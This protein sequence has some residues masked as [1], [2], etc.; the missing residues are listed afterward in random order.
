MDQLRPL[1]DDALNAA[2][3]AFERLR[4]R[5]FGIASR[6]LGSVSEAEDVV[7]DVWVRWQ[8]ADRSSV[9]D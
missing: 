7:Q 1:P 5:L 9:L 6:V 8:G 2:A 3:A 4:P